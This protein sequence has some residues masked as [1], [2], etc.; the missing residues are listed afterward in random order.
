MSIGANKDTAEFVMDNI[1]YH[2]NN[3]IRKHYPQADKILILCDGGGSNGCRHHIVKE[4]F[5]KLSKRLNMEIVVAHY[6]AYCSKWNPIEHR[7]FSF[8]SKSWQGVVFDSYE[9]IKELAEATTTKTGFSV[10]AYI[11]EKQYLTGK[12]ASVEFMERM[13]VC[14]D[15]FLPK[16]NHKFCPN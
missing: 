10:K 14:F 4:A 1:E 12:K 8:I 3:S 6:P 16:W 9:I 15:E 11:N 2:W 13:P 5:E 7:A